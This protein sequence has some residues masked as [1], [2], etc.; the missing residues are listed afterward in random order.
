MQNTPAQNN[1]PPGINI[2]ALN[3]YLNQ[4]TYENINGNMICKLIV[5]G[6]SMT[7]KSEIIES[8]NQCEDPNN[9]TNVKCMINKDK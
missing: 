8:K 1:L 4:S 3:E 2:D 6:T 9:V 7:I 5:N